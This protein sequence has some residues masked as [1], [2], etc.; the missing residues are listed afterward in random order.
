MENIFATQIHITCFPLVAVP[1]TNVVF[2][3]GSGSGNQENFEIQKTIIEGFVNA[4]DSPKVRY[5]FQKFG[6]FPLSFNLEQYK[7]KE[8]FLRIL[9]QENS[10]GEGS[11]DDLADALKE[12]SENAF[13]YAKHADENNIVVVFVEE[14]PSK[15]AVENAQNIFQ[16]SVK[17]VAV[18]LGN[19]LTRSDLQGLAINLNNVVVV[20]DV[21]DDKEKVIDKIKYVVTGETTISTFHIFDT[22]NSRPLSAF[23]ITESCFLTSFLS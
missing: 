6:K 14:Q 23:Q 22:R 13:K 3:L 20:T 21:S 10:V 7:S 9:E 8:N 12:T 2:I 5:G 16:N 4:Y 17:I 19:R 11:S 15:E 18:V 1:P